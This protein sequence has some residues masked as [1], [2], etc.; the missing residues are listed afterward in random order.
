VYHGLMAPRSAETPALSDPFK[1]L[2]T[3]DMEEGGL[4]GGLE[5]AGNLM[6]YIGSNLDATGVTMEEWAVLRTVHDKLITCLQRD[7]AFRH[8]LD[9][10]YMCLHPRGVLHNKLLWEDH[11]RAYEIMGTDPADGVDGLSLGAPSPKAKELYLFLDT[12]INLANPR[13]S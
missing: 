6:T 7:L 12:K 1:P 10:I 13:G 11:Q 2:S 4:L 5:A 9:L 8:E 3:S